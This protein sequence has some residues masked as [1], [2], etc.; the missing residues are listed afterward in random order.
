VFV[1]AFLDTRM[2][3]HDLPASERR[4]LLH[5]AAHDGMAGGQI[6]DAHMA[7]IARA[8]GAAVIVTDNRRDVLGALRDG[9][10]VETPR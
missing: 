2:A 7:E 10:R 8:A 5:A 6:C 1:N 3:V 4:A 9:M